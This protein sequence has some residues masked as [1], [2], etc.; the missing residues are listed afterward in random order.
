VNIFIHTVG[1]RNGY[2]QKGRDLELGGKKICEM[3]RRDE[4]EEK[5]QVRAME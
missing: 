3:E 1:E 4:K 5:E 2:S